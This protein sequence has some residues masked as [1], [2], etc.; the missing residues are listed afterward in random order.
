M[1]YFKK[2]PAVLLLEDGQ[3]YHG[4]SIGGI[5]TSAGEIC[6]NTGMTGYQ[7]IFSDPSYFGQLL[8]MTNAHIGNYGTLA[9]D[10]ESKG[11]KISGL[12]CKNFSQLYSRK[13]ADQSLNQ[14][15][16][17]N[18]II[19][20]S[21]VDTRAIVRHI[22]NKGAMNAIISSED[23]DIESLKNKLAKIP[24]MNGL[25][26]ATSVCTKEAYSYGPDTA[27]YKI[28]VLDLGVKTSILKNLAALHFQLKVFPAKTTFQEMQQW[29]PDGYFFS[30]GPGDPAPL[31]F[32]IETARHILD[33][34][35][36][37]F[38]IC[39]GHQ[40]LARALGLDTFKMHHGHRGANHPVLNLETGRSEITTQ[41]HGF[42]VDAN[43]LKPF[44]N[45]I[46]LTHQNLNDQTIE[47]FRLKNRKAFSVQFHPE[48]SPGPHDSS[49][50]FEQFKQYLTQ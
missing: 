40:V 45:Q 13:Q 42:A 35:I 48:A 33:A 3:A 5:G 9:D 2:V 7:E 15:L 46:I 20:I 37:F 49:Y 34:D 38:G 17:D 1:N 23:Q 36:A 4:Y 30:N 27:T 6:F 43:S 32:A 41:N 18:H 50:L 31:D 26:L 28:A 47:G 24:S 10:Q 16:I 12:I 25:E 44:S 39:L 21:D 22:R 29:Q 14:S 19:G 8:V 11:M